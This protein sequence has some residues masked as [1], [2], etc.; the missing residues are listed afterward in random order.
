MFIPD[1][2]T[3]DTGFTIKITSVQH[4]TYT[5]LTG[6]EH[7]H[8]PIVAATPRAKRDVRIKA[9]IK[10]TFSATYPATTADGHPP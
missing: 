6:S 7:P 10:V 8:L 2:Y 9:A 4:F 5:F 3:I 1:V